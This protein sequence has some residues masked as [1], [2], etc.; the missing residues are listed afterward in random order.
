M[1]IADKAKDLF[2]ATA[3]Q[4]PDV[5]SGIVLEGVVGTV[6]PGVSG[7]M[8]AYRQKRQERIYA[9]FLEEI[10]NKI[11]VMEKRV[12]RLSADAL[13]DFKDKY[14]GM[15]SDY[16]LEEVQERKV[17]YLANGLIN[18][19]G[20][21]QVNEDFVLTYYDT[22]H[23]LRIRDILVLNRYRDL[24][25]LQKPEESYQEFLC[26]LGINEEQYR[27]IL[28]KLERM[29]L[30]ETKR[31]QKEDDLYSNLMAIQEYLEKLGKGKNASLGRL[32]RLERRDA[33][34]ISRYGR[35]FIQFFD[36]VNDEN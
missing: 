1:N 27:A 15:V 22:L 9:A 33:Y 20:M 30:L 10:K 28:E 13:I 11:E 32:K 6:V 21:E 8:L 3:E 29:G 26:H 36:E 23:D 14:F 5:I 2:A 7:A 18:L 4:A 16:V 12:N 19:A 35:Q 25:I 17:Q 34:R 24:A 31:A